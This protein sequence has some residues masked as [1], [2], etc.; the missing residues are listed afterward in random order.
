MFDMLVMAGFKPGV[1]FYKHHGGIYM[2]GDAV[3]YLI[4]NLHPE[5]A[6][7]LEQNLKAQEFGMKDLPKIPDV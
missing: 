1:N 2:D 3:N 4:K 6:E 5:M 7:D